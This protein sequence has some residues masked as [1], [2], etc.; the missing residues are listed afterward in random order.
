VSG[1][2]WKRWD[3]LTDQE[4]EQLTWLIDSLRRYEAG[5]GLGVA[6]SASKGID[7][8][9]EF[10]S[11]G[12][13]VIL[14][15]F[16]ARHEKRGVLPILRDTGCSDIASRIEP[17]LVRPVGTTVFIEALGLYRARLIAH[18]TF[19]FKYLEEQYEAKGLNTH[20]GIAAYMDSLQAV[21]NQT[22]TLLPVLS[23]RYPEA[24]RWWRRPPVD[25]GP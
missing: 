15:A 16:Y 9:R 7:H 10:I 19:S 3:E 17:I 23:R 5:R 24:A 14:Y 25:D 11:D 4:Q 13:V 18:P 2:A 8:R 6:L 21:Q 22:D 20:E 1:M 12:L